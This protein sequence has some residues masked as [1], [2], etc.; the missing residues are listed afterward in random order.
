MFIHNFGPI[1]R[2]FFFLGTKRNNETILF[3]KRNE[4]KRNVI[5]VKRNE[6]DR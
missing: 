1:H 6:T 5:F 3:V 4:T 2:Q